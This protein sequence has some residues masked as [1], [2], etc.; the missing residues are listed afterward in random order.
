M[1]TVL[2]GV[3]VCSVRAAGVKGLVEECEKEQGV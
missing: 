3:L 1:Y 2:G